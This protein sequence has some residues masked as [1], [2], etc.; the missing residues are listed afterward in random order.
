MVLQHANIITMLTCWYS[1]DQVH[2]L[3]VIMVTFANTRILLAILFIGITV[4]HK[5][6][7][8]KELTY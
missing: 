8:L 1:P 2:Y 6:K 7:H 3:V 4:R 5:P